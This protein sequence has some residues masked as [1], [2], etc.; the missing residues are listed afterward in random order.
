MKI[1]LAA[2]AIGVVVLAGCEAKLKW[3]DTTG[4]DRPDSVEAA[5]EALCK[6]KTVPSPEPEN[7]SRDEWEEI[8][9]HMR[10]CMS[11]KG[12][13]PVAREN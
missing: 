8:W 6:A 10:T 2:F 13:K 1:H 12:W 11:D 9:G 7:L 4:Q 5:D 3:R